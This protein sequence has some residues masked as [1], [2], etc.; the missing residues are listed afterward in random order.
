MLAMLGDI[1]LKEHLRFRTPEGTMK[2]VYLTE[3]PLAFF[4]VFNCYVF[5]CGLFSFFLLDDLYLGVLDHHPPLAL[6]WKAIFCAK[7]KE[8][9]CM[10]GKGGWVGN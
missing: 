5:F 7:R 4:L 3:D 1:I 10:C 9:M 2:W 8:I 6:Q